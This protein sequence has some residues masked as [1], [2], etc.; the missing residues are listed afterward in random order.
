MDAVLCITKRWLQPNILPA[1]DV[2]VRVTRDWFI[3]APPPAEHKVVGMKGA[4]TLRDVTAV[5]KKALAS[6]R[7]LAILTIVRAFG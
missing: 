1:T 4:H 5:L 6:L 7:N 2:T 3:C